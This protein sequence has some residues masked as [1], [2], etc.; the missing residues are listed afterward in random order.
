MEIFD[1][2]YFSGAHWYK[3]PQE[4]PHFANGCGGATFLFQYEERG[5]GTKNLNLK[6]SEKQ[7]IS[8]TL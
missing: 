5:F 1:G 3:A 4:A 8:H 7:P 6:R 2:I